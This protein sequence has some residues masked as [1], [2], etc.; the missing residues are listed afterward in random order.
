MSTRSVPVVAVIAFL[1][2]A[3][4]GCVNSNGMPEPDKVKASVES[5]GGNPDHLYQELV[6]F[7]T[8]DV[9]SYDSQLIYLVPTKDGK[10]FHI[11]DARGEIYRDYKDFIREN[12]L[13]G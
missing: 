7:K 9:K 4:G 2:L 1:M 10:G 8:L 3:L 6:V 11:V 12:G 13:T 5:L